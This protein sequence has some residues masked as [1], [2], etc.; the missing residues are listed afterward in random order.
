[1][2]KVSVKKIK[3]LFVRCVKGNFAHRTLEN[4]GIANDYTGTTYDTITTDKRQVIVPV[5]YL[6]VP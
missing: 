1:M 3:H 5:Q 2:V 6:L 4:F